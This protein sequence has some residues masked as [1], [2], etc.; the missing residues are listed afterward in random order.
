M[1]LIQ[2]NSTIDNLKLILDNNI[3]IGI[4]A[5]FL[6]MIPIACAFYFFPHIIYFLYMFHCLVSYLPLSSLHPSL[7][8][9]KYKYFVPLSVIDLK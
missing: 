5:L 1:I 6:I 7:L 4:C 9:H 8:L 2:F 3:F